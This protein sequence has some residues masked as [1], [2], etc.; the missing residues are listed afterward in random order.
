[1]HRTIE[2]IQLK[3]KKIVTGV[4]NVYFVIIS[5]ILIYIFNSITVFAVALTLFFLIS[6]YSSG[7][8]YLR[9]MKLPTLFIIPALF[10][11][12]FITPGEKI[13]LVFSREGIDLAFKTFLR[14]YASLSIMVY[15]IVTTSIPEML[16]ALRKLRLPDF[17]AEI[18][19]LIY[20]TIQIFVDELMRLE[21]SAESRLGFYGR[22]NMLRTSALL[23]YS[24]F[25]KS[26][27]RAEKL[28]MAMESRCYNGKIPNPSNKSSGIGYALV[29]IA[30]IIAAGVIS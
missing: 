10:V 21:R 23:G 14:T 20:R 18:M 1:M 9:F 7:L 29:V 26:M 16:F 3:S 22:K 2:E 30:A 4:A 11:I 19:T 28:N 15:L 17:V 25:I 5:F 27:E 6:I 12:A 24:M 13:F 8:N